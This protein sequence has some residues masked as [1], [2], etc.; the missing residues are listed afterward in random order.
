MGSGVRIGSRGQGERTTET[1][2][3]AEG[4]R[5]TELA[6]DAGA[7]PKAPPVVAEHTIRGDGLA[8]GA[9]DAAPAPDPAEK[10]EGGIRGDGLAEDA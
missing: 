3:D 7:E 1:P 8:E 5:G 2:E 6:D 9:G 4:I 10:A